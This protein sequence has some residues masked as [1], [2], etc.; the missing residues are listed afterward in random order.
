[1]GFFPTWMLTVAVG[2]DIWSPWTHSNLILS[3][4]FTLNGFIK[5]TCAIT[6][7]AP[8]SNL[9]SVSIP[10]MYP[11]HTQDGTCS[12]GDSLAL[13]YNASLAMFGFL[14]IPFDVTRFFTASTSD[15]GFCIRISG[16]LLICLWLITFLYSLTLITF[17]P[18]TSRPIPTIFWRK[19]LPCICLNTPSSLV[20]I[21]CKTCS[22]S[23][24][25]RFMFPHPNLNTWGHI[26]YQLLHYQDFS[27]FLNVIYI[28]FNPLGEKIFEPDI[29]L[30]IAFTGPFLKWPESLSI[31]FLSNVISPKDSFFDLNVSVT[32]ISRHF[33]IGSLCLACKVRD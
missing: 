26:V 22:L 31:G 3:L 21:I 30:S 32:I 13:V 33:G 1:M 12:N 18:T 8:E 14:T 29:H 15:K 5:S 7:S 24:R 2:C 9:I 27:N 28:R 17:S 4:C 19:F 20:I 6:T 11:V 23:T 10:S 16:A 25:F